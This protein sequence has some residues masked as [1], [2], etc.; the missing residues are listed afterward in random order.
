MCYFTSTLLLVK[1]EKIDERYSTV[2]VKHCKYSWFRDCATKRCS[3]YSWKIT[4]INSE[5]TNNKNFRQLDMFD[6]TTCF[7]TWYFLSP[8]FEQK[9]A[10]IFYFTLHTIFMMQYLSTR[11]WC[12]VLLH[13]CLRKK[14][15]RSRCSIRY[16][17]LFCGSW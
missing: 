14:W 3:R 10:Q 6:I 11:I 2:F 1:C 16:S 7:A 9:V 8:L 12:K 5:F 4:L 13:V 15:A 17:T